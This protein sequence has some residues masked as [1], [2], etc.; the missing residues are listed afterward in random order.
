MSKL[1][2]LTKARFFSGVVAVIMGCVLNYFGDRLLGV[3]S[4]HP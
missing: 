3:I 2:P 1:P 4:R